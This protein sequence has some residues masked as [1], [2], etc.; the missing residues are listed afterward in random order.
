MSET[1]AVSTH[2]NFH[3]GELVDDSDENIWADSKDSKKATKNEFIGEEA[4]LNYY[5][6]FRKVSQDP[7]RYEN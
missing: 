7:Q 2:A 4:F 5:K 3:R 1:T 6:K